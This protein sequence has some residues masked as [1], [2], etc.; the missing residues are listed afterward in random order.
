MDYKKDL[1]NINL[2]FPESFEILKKKCIKTQLTKQVKKILGNNIDYVIIDFN[3]LTIVPYLHIKDYTVR[4]VNFTPF[5]KSY[6]LLNQIK[7]TLSP[8]YILGVIDNGVSRK[9][10]NILNYKGHRKHSVHKNLA[11]TSKNSDDVYKVN[12]K[13]LFD[14]MSASKNMYLDLSY[15]EADHKIGFFVNKL[16]K[17]NENLNIIVLSS[18]ND[19]LQLIPF[20]NVLLYRKG[21]YVIMK[22]GEIDCLNEF[23]DIYLPHPFYFLYYKAL[24]GDNV[25]NIPSIISK[26]KAQSVFKELADADII[27][28]LNIE[29]FINYIYKELGKNNTA[30]ENAKI[31]FLKNLFAVN[32]LN[33][34]IFEKN[35]LLLL[36]SSYEKMKESFKEENQ[37][38]IETI[39]EKFKFVLKR[40]E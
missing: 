8:E 6:F 37:K 13:Y 4:N 22:K 32:M 23:L 35:E 5:I 25:D 36:N 14:Y 19:Y 40:N 39:K 29:G 15:G 17:E 31:Q 11:L 2:S 3:S 30:R 34:Q 38:I 33:E 18:D 26:R 7:D 27:H 1:E 12:V 20:A 28:P 24:T 21:K 16:L 10:K 9:L